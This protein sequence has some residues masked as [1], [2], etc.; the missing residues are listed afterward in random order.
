MC[1]LVSLYN[2]VTVDSGKIIEIASFFFGC[3]L[4]IWPC[5]PEMSARQ[6]KKILNE[7]QVTKTVHTR[8]SLYYT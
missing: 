1:Q 8:R 6:E 2:F 4:S 7:F 5:F 3:N